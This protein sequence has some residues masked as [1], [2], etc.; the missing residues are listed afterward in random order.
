V[1]ERVARTYHATISY[2]EL[3]DKVQHVTGIHTRVLLMN[4][5][6][7]VRGDVSRISHRRGQPMLSAL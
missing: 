6:G 5:I 2:K 7:Q 3:G 1:L 4:S